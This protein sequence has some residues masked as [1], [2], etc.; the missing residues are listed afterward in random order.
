MLCKYTFKHILN[1]QMLAYPLQSFPQ[2]NILLLLSPIFSKVISSSRQSAIPSIFLFISWHRC[3]WHICSPAMA[4]GQCHHTPTGG[5]TTATV[6]GH[7][8]A[9]EESYYTDLL[10][11]AH[12]EDRRDHSPITVSHPATIKYL[13]AEK[14]PWFDGS[15]KLVIW[16]STFNLKY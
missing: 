6:R 16:N 13:R 2:L 14:R 15:L 3:C 10:R 8:N 12:V 4:V 1:I 5:A 7:L 9:C 11:Y